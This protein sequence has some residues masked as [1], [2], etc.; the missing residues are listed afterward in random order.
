MLV[1]VYTWKVENDNVNLS[2]S[3]MAD[4][5]DRGDQ[6]LIWTN[7]FYR[8]LQRKVQTI[9]VSAQDGGSLSKQQKVIF[10]LASGLSRCKL[11][12]ICN[13]HRKGIA[14]YAVCEKTDGERRLFCVIIEERDKVSQE[15]TRARIFAVD[16][17][18]N[19]LEMHRDIALDYAKGFC[20]A[21]NSSLMI[22]DGELV[23]PSLFVA[24]DVV[25]NGS[26]NFSRKHLDDRVSEVKRIIGNAQH[27]IVSKYTALDKAPLAVYAKLYRPLHALKKIFLR[28]KSPKG[29]STE[30]TVYSPLERD[31]KLYQY[32]CKS[33]G[34]IFT[35][36]DKSYVDLLHDG[37][38]VYKWKRSENN[39]IDFALNIDEVQ[40]A[41]WNIKSVG[42]DGAESKTTHSASLTVPSWGSD[43]DVKPPG[44]DEE[45]SASTKTSLFNS[46][47]SPEKRVDV[48][49]YLMGYPVLDTDPNPMVVV[50]FASLPVSFLENIIWNT[51]EGKHSFEWR[52]RKSNYVVFE[53]KYSL[54][55]SRWEPICV[56]ADKPRPNHISVGWNTIELL[57]ER[58]DDI[59]IC[60]C[61]K[62]AW[63][64]FVE[65]A[66][67]A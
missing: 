57:A 37:N 43:V 32:T 5:T 19:I 30:H 12:Q 52:K 50:K 27:Y 14:P 40:T 3:I 4:R 63:P 17:A 53:S 59:D 10:P 20:P 66:T 16:R 58:L 42:G 29:D 7:T 6:K 64:A 67:P 39:T 25:Y 26:K 38:G 61:S 36:M 44:L 11:S 28:L 54:K 2:K 24:F 46:L 9:I 15:I 23:K 51:T 34:I 35:P 62:T 47:S 56:R 65:K 21:D 60:E 55:H 1:L 49:L 8:E 41:L 18:L 48:K 45:P 33:D 31:K 13:L 22:L